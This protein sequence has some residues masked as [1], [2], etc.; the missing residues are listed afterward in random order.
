MIFKLILGKFILAYVFKK[1]KKE[2]YNI[3]YLISIW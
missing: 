2:S 1:I 3:K